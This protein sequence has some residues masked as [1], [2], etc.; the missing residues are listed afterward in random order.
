MSCRGKRERFKRLKNILLFLP[1]FPS[2]PEGLLCNILILFLFVL[3]F[4]KYFFVVVRLRLSFSLILESHKKKL[5]LCSPSIFRRF[6]TRDYAQRR[7]ISFFIFLL[8]SCCETHPYDLASA[9]F[10]SLSLS[11]YHLGR[12]NMKD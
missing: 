10:L 2:Y 12:I 1:H 4:A 6:L 9:L 5:K 11:R 3:S 7:Q 8:S